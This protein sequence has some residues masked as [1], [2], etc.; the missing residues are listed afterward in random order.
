MRTRRSFNVAFSLKQQK[1]V[2]LNGTETRGS[3]FQKMCE[4]NVA[5]GE[6]KPTSG[7]SLR[8]AKPAKIETNYKTE[9]RFLLNST[10]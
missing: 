2:T 9:A 6:K 8:A 7:D 1:S 4:T 10:T 5:Q 3:E